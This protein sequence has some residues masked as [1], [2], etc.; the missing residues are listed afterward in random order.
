MWVLVRT[1]SPK[2]FQRVQQSMFWIKNKKNRYTP[3]DSCFTIQKW[4]Y[5][6]LYIT[7]TCCPDDKINIKTTQETH[8]ITKQFFVNTL[9]KKMTPV[10]K[11]LHIAQY[12]TV[13]NIS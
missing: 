3:V 6:D 9:E 12:D 1:A 2:W 5:M 4:G 8:D 11:T 13:Y 7:R 10:P